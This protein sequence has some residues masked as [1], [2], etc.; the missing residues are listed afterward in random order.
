MMLNQV[1]FTKQI[2][3]MPAQSVTWHKILIAGLCRHSHFK[4]N[5][6]MR[7][8]MEVFPT[9]PLSSLIDTLYIQFSGDKKMTV[10]ERMHETE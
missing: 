3:N 4:H 9:D 6:R 1:S 2:E 7:I 5:G 10:K 8:V